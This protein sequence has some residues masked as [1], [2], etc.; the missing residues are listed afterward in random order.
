MR[1]EFRGLSRGRPFRGA[2]PNQSKQP[3]GSKRA[4]PSCLSPAITEQWAIPRQKPPLPPTARAVSPER[5]A[6]GACA[7]GTVRRC[8]NHH[9]GCT[10]LQN[11]GRSGAHAHPT[12][13]H[14]HHS[15]SHSPPLA[16]ED[17]V[18]GVA[19][20]R[21]RAPSL[22]RIRAA[23]AP[24]CYRNRIPRQLACDASEGSKL[25]NHAFFSTHSPGASTTL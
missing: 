19:E 3:Q 4:A 10:H 2:A 15:S 12:Q 1:D 23:K 22:T 6:P 5:S 20:P 16:P 9:S 24:N 7:A 13:A 14:T 18:W 17:E 11:S 8:A 25:T 21:P